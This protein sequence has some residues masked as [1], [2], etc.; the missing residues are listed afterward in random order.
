MFGLYNLTVEQY[1]NCE[2]NFAAFSATADE[3]YMI[4]LSLNLWLPKKLT[5][6]AESRI[7]KLG[8]DV[9]S[10]ITLFYTGSRYFLAD[11]FPNLFSNS[12]G[13]GSGDVTQIIRTLNGGDVTRNEAILKVQLW[14]ALKQLEDMA[15]QA[16][17]IKKANKK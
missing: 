13:E 5:R 1:L 16:E 3:K 14:D 12:T 10:A 9:K 17:R 4:R 6:H 11:N 8:D 15:I 7:S 2:N